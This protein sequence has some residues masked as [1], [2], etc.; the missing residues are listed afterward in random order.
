MKRRNERIASSS[1]DLSV[2]LEN[3]NS[4]S[5]TRLTL[6]HQTYES[7]TERE[8]TCDFQERRGLFGQLV[9]IVSYCASRVLPNLVAYREV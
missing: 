2:S 4:E 9:R 3:R 5:A 8:S 6:H 7:T 1:M